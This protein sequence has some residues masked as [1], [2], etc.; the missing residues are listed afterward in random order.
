MK[1]TFHFILI[2]G[3]DSG[4]NDGIFLHAHDPVEQ[5]KY[6]GSLAPEFCPHLVC[7]YWHYN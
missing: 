5:S 4:Y 7:R 1:K 6:F 3:D 2:P